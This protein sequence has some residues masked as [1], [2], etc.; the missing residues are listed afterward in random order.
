MESGHCD[1]SKK[2]EETQHVSRSTIWRMERT[3]L[4]K[5]ISISDRTKI[6]LGL[7]M[8]EERSETRAELY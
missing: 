4:K 3:C 7:L 6:N 2:D 8:A 5:E 1:T